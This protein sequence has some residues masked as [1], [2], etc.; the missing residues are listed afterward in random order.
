MKTRIKTSSLIAALLLGALSGFAGKSFADDSATKV[1]VSYRFF[2][3]NPDGS[4]G[5]EL[6]DPQPNDGVPEASVR[7]GNKFIVRTQMQGDWSDDPKG[8]YSA[9]HDLVVANDDNAP[10]PKALYLWGEYN[11]LTI[12]DRVRSGSFTLKFGTQSTA[13]IA[14][15]YT[16]YGFCDPSASAAAIRQA[17]GALTNVGTDN[18]RVVGSMVGTNFR[19]DL[20]FTGAK[21]RQDMQNLAVASNGLVDRSG[22]PVAVVMSNNSADPSQPSVSALGRKHNL[23]NDYPDPQRPGSLAAGTRY[24][25]VVAGALKPYDASTSTRVLGMIGGSSTKSQIALYEAVRTTN[26]VD[27]TFTAMQAGRIKV[28]GSASAAASGSGKLG[29]AVLGQTGAPQFLVGSQLILKSGYVNI[30][31]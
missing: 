4:A 8:I 16:A 5:A 30:T 9:Y 23:N 2:A 17:L 15:V 13:P 31:N 12:G 20:N 19:F 7:V 27:A 25:E 10:A 26:V 3:V 29:V 14:L 28:S 22:S 18:I 21:A 11:L 1:K 24:S 6:P